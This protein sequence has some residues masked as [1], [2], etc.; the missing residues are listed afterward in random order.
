[1]EAGKVD[2]EKKYCK[3]DIKLHDVYTTAPESTEFLCAYAFNEYKSIHKVNHSGNLRKWQCVSKFC[4][5]QVTLTKKYPT[6]RVNTKLAFCPTN[7]WFVSD[8]DLVHSPSCDSV[9]KCS[10]QI[11]MELPGFKSSLVKGFSSARARV[12]SSVKT[13]DNVN[14]DHRPALV[15]GAISRARKMMEEEDDKYDKYDKLPSFLRSFARESWIHSIMSIAVGFSERSC[16]L[17]LLL[18]DRTT[19]C[20]YLNVMDLI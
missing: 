5:W 7:A 14:V 12:A 13:T 9:R 17:V 15:Y 4:D 8:L 16:R 20:H 19:G 6:K 1:M 2:L 10:S 18:Q 3:Q 11:L